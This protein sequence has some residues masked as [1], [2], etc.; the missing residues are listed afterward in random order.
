MIGPVLQEIGWVNLLWN[1]V[2]HLW[3]YAFQELTPQGARLQMDAM[4][5]QFDTGN[6][7]REALFRAVSADSDFDAAKLAQVKALL[8][9]TSEAATIRNSLM[10]ADFHLGLEETSREASLHVST[11]FGRKVNK[12]TQKDLVEEL[13]KLTRSLKQ[14]IG[15]MESQLFAPLPPMPAGAPEMLTTSKFVWWLEQIIQAER[16]K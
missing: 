14:L 16:S 1:K 2:E 8:D 5:R 12:L 13:D 11:G 15:D 6:K 7:Q 9:R 4:Y 3:F 10:H